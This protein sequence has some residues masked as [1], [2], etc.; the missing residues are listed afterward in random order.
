MFS[1]E[2]LIKMENS[3]IQLAITLNL[4]NNSK[5]RKYHKNT[6]KIFRLY[7]ETKIMTK[8]VFLKT[9]PMPMV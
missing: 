6:L 5:F 3:N 2:V 8:S 1:T 4:R 7:E 9:A